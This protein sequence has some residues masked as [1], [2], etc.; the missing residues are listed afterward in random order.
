MNEG[1]YAFLHCE[2]VMLENFNMV[3]NYT[4][5]YTRNME[6]HNCKLQA[7][8]AFWHTENVTVYDS[9]ISGE[10]LAWYAKNIKFV[11]CKFSGTQPFC[12][13]ENL[14]LENCTFDS[15]CDL[16][17]EYTTVQATIKGNVTS[18][19]NPLGGYI[20]CD[21]C[22]ELILDDHC[23]NRGECKITIKD[24]ESQH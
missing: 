11:N 12:Y 2:N 5:Q 24:Q 13:V 20:T 22:S 16:A 14:T 8:D 23:R 19:K 9:E 6:I 4:F 17:F 7:K 3:G 21:S 18:I 10:Y 1:R 15:S